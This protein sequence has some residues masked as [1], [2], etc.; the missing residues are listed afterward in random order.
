MLSFEYNYETHLEVMRREGLAEGHVKG[1]AEG[2]VKGMEEG[3]QR[4]REKWQ[5]VVAG[6]DAEIARL[7]AQLGKQ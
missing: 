1:L 5:G 4:E 2:H 6:K 3:E 7:R